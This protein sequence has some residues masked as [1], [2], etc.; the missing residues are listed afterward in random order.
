LAELAPAILETDETSLI[1]AAARGD[2]DAF[3]AL[4]EPLHRE[5]HL[6]CYR[7]LGSFQDA[8]DCLQETSLKAW[9][10]IDTFDRRASFRAWMYRIATNTCLDAL[11]KRRRRVLPQDLGAPIDPAQPI[12]A[13]RLDIP[14][15]EPYPDALLGDDNPEAIVELRESVRLAFVRALQL[16]P[17]RQRAVL[18][19]REVLD[20][21]AAEVAAMLESSVPA[22]NSALQRARAAIARHD[23]DYAQTGPDA[24]LDAQKTELLARYIAAWEAGD[25]EAVVALLTEDAI[26]SMPPWAEWFE[27]RETLRAA[28]G[29]EVCWGGPP[30]PGVFRL[31]PIALNGEIALAEYQRDGP[32]DRYKPIALTAVAFSRD[33]S[34]IRE[35]T[36]FARPELFEKWGFPGTIA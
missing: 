21:S 32:A 28:Y 20:W 13:A 36:S 2:P 24:R 19:L 10:R 9:R 16:L 6:F 1:G 31:L 22:V 26:Q 12:G 8:E 34:R 29:N 23:P 14:W 3:R 5:L 11:R 17:A 4:V 35:L 33:G 25:I 7:M 18:I 15:L 27:G 30:R